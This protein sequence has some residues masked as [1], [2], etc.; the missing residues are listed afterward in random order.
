MSESIVNQANPRHHLGLAR[1]LMA[2]ATATVTMNIAGAIIAFAMTPFIAPLLHGF[3]RDPA[4]EGL[5]FPALVGGYGVIA[6]ALA[7]LYPRIDPSLSLRAGVELGGALG[8]A[9]FFGGHL[10]ISGWSRMPV[11]AMATS[12]T[13]DSLAVAAGGF[14][15]A[16]VYRIGRASTAAAKALS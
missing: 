8:L 1:P 16:L 9:I 10:V 2:I 4:G 13:F 12:G 6:A 5:L 11:G 3:M 15:T 14:T 7:Y